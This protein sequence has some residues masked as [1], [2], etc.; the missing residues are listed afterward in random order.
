MPLNAWFIDL[1]E[2]EHA[3]WKI[4]QLQHD[5]AYKE[6]LQFMQEQ[7]KVCPICLEEPNQRMVGTCGH[8]FCRVCIDRATDQCYQVNEPDDVAL[9]AAYDVLDA[10]NELIPDAGYISCPICPVCRKTSL[11]H[12]VF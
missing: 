11:F 8:S 12:K 4:Y 6:H 3:E 9:G 7:E 2:L 5:I 10:V 1:E